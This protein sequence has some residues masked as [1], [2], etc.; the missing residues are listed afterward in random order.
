ML[1][2]GEALQ[3]LFDDGLRVPRTA[4]GLHVPDRILIAVFPKLT[5]YGFGLGRGMFPELLC[6]LEK[7]GATGW[8]IRQARWVVFG[9]GRQSR[10]ETCS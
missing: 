2:F 1:V 9:S 6:I 7:S 10:G 4:A 8:A 3:G 5:L